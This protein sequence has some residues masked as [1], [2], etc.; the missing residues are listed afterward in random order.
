MREHLGQL[1]RWSTG[2]APAA[3]AVVVR[4][5]ASAPLPAGSVMAVGPRGEAVGSVSGGCVESA[6]YAEC[7]DAM[8]TGRPVLASYGVSDDD[9]LEA[10]L[11]C[12]GTLEVFVT[13]LDDRRFPG[14]PELCDLVAADVPVAVATVLRTSRRGRSGTEPGARLVITETES[15]GTTG[16]DD[17]D[18]ALYADLPVLLAAGETRV[19][20]YFAAEDTVEVFV[21]VFAP[22][23]RLIVFGATDFAAALAGAGAFLG[24]RIT[25]CDARPVFAVPDRFPAADEVV[26]RWPHEYL[27]AE[28]EAG[29]VD[30]R[31]AICVLTHDERFDRP[32]LALALDTE[33]LGYV[34]AMGS[35][36]T[37]A[38]R[39]AA[40]RADGVDEAAIDRLRSPIGLDLQ[41]R[42][43][44]ETAVSIVAEILAE[45]GGG[46]GRR[47]T[48]SPGPIHSAKSTSRP[49]ARS[50]H[51]IGVT[52]AEAR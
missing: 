33:V 45:R 38:R 14:L 1:A 50:P 15:W 2:G 5:F 49:V 19:A 13:R 16:S 27:A 34:G 39:L 37:H 10:G 21:Q 46:T 8:A 40:L 6:V 43:P 36:R 41:A 12:G 31:T 4:T 32:L 30:D 51:S 47:L 29:R 48:E 28:I 26:R 9:A 44:Q 7:V 11:T 52:A 18:A 17:L 22:R 23:P 20:D 35:R 24:Y 3:V 42:T 25:V